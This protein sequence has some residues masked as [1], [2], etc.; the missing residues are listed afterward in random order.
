[1]KN[2]IVIVKSM[3]TMSQ[4]K[5]F[6]LLRFW[7]WFKWAEKITAK[8]ATENSLFKLLLK[9]LYQENTLENALGHWKGVRINRSEYYA[10]YYYRHCWKGFSVTLR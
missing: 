9:K 2:Y 1:M 7:Q 10:R 4:S 5:T 6:R 3:P 8:Q